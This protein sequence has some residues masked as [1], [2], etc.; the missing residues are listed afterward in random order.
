MPQKRIIAT[1]SEKQRYNDALKRV[2]TYSNTTAAYKFQ[3]VSEG[4]QAD[5]HERS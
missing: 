1:F 5:P 4:R 3:K 2:L